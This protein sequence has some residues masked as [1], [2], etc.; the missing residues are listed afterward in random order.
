MI[1]FLGGRAGQEA[2]ESRV[3]ALLQRL[4]QLRTTI[5]TSEKGIVITSGVIIDSN[6]PT[7]KAQ[8]RTKGL[9]QAQHQRALNGG[10][11]LDFVTLQRTFKF[12]TEVDL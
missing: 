12:A 3:A 2:A 1:P 10:A 11:R 5:P 7:S 4:M 8:T 9:V 6:Q